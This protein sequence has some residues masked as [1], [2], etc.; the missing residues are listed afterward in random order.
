LVSFSTRGG[1]ATS[2]E[3]KDEP[4]VDVLLF[5]WLFVV[6][7]L[8]I[9]IGGTI[10]SLASQRDRCAVLVPRRPRED[11]GGLTWRLAMALRII[12][13]CGYVIQGDDDDELWRNAQGHMG[14]LHPE[15]V[16]NVTRED[17]LAQAEQL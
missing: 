4:N 9:A 10:S 5:I 3:F 6:I 15:L 13:M 1:W 14:V 17:L 8:L 7:T 2:G 16:G 12:C 11:R